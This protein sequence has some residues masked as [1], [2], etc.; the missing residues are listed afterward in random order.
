MQRMNILKLGTKPREE[1]TVLAIRLE[2]SLLAE[3]ESLAK[4]EGMKAS[5]AARQL[6]RYY[7]DGM[8]K[9]PP[10]KRR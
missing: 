5:V 4:A 10:R 8:T 1:T 6:V 2:K 7:V 9:S 3:L